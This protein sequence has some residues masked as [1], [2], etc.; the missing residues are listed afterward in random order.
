MRQAEVDIAGVKFV[1]L[2]GEGRGGRGGWGGVATWCSV[3]ESFARR[4]CWMKEKAMRKKRER[5]EGSVQ[6]SAAVSVK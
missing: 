4:H 5:R 2:A 3:S 6:C 1:S